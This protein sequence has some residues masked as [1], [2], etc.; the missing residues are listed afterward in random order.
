MKQHIVLT[1][2]TSKDKNKIAQWNSEDTINH[3]GLGTQQSHRYIYFIWQYTEVIANWEPSQGY[4]N[5]NNK[6]FILFVVY[7]L[8]KQYYSIYST[9]YTWSNSK[10]LSYI[11]VRHEW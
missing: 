10:S 4:I 9:Q 7:E 5:P 11:C 6:S 3:E 2:A 1:M 8:Y